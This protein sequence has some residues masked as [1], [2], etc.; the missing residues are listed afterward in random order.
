M[1]KTLLIALAFLPLVLCA[2]RL[3]VIGSGGQMLSRGGLS[4]TATIGEVFVAV[5]SGPDGFATE[6]FQQGYLLSDVAASRTEKTSASPIAELYPNPAVDRVRVSFE[7]LG[8][9]PVH[10]KMYNSVG[11]LLETVKTGSNTHDFNVT[12]LP[13]G[14]YWI[15]VQPTDNHPTLS[16]PFEK[17]NH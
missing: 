8:D 9:Q 5:P 2:Q 12:A 3:E 7:K 11:R 4:I 17:V 14:H 6:G 10:L 15:S 13:A 1:R 16:L